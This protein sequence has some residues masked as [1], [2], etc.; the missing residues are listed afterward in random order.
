VA[1]EVAEPGDNP[2]EDQCSSRRVV[3]VG[4]MSAIDLS[5]I[6]RRWEHRD[7]RHMSAR[8]FGDVH[9]TATW[10]GAFEEPE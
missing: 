6:L 8:S 9:M 3:Q 1:P 4:R 5:C 7:P 2:D 10:S